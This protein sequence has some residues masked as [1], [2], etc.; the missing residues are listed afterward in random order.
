[1]QLIHGIEAQSEVSKQD[2]QKDKTI[3]KCVFQ[4]KHPM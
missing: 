4:M 2:P 1:M 3:L